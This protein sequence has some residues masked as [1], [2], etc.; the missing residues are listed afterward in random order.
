MSIT[1]IALW[2][3]VCAEDWAAESAIKASNDNRESRTTLDFFQYYQR[4]NSW[5]NCRPPNFWVNFLLFS[6]LE[7]NEAE[8]EVIYD[9]YFKLFIELLLLLLLFLCWGRLIWLMSDITIRYCIWWPSPLTPHPPTP[10]PARLSRL[11]H[12][13]RTQPVYSLP[14]LNLSVN[15]LSL[16]MNGT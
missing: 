1:N 13:P 5:R 12:P 10:D 14:S 7:L 3:G 15:C 16:F 11:T 8:C 2:I 6:C 4:N 9:L